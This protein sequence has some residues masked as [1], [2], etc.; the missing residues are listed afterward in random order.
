MRFMFLMPVGPGSNEEWLREAVVSCLVGQGVECGVLLIDDGAGLCRG[1]ESPHVKVV[2]LARNVGV[3]AAL[4]EGWA[5]LPDDC[6]FVARMDADDICLP[7]RLQDQLVWMSGRPMAAVCGA[8]ML[9]VHGPTW[10]N[11]RR[12]FSP[13]TGGIGSILAM[14]RVP[15]WHPTVLLRRAAIEEYVGKRPWPEEYP[16]AEDYAL[17]CKFFKAAGEGAFIRMDV[18]VIGHREHPGRASAVYQEEQ[19]RS[20]EMARRRLLDGEELVGDDGQGTGEDVAGRGDK[21]GDAGPR[22]RRGGR[23]KPK[24]EAEAKPGDSF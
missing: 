2:E 8:G 13:Q 14:G 21:R 20:K 1:M 4:N 19:L 11:D 9:R 22:P 15:V 23:S 24:P 3:A 7:G 16:W 5:S 6:E 17:W 18:P 10:L 12:A